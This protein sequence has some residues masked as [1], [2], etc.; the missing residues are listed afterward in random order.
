MLHIYMRHAYI[1]MHVDGA[2]G[3]YMTCKNICMQ[4][5][6]VY[7]HV[8]ICTYTHRNLIHTYICIHTCMHTVCIHVCIRTYMHRNLSSQ[9][10]ADGQIAPKGM[11]T[12]MYSCMRE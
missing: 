10:L 1:Y 2:L 6:H 5:I 8:C 4:C 12:I 11:S 7:I 9:T 3:K